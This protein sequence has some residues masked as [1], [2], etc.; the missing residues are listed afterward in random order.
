[1]KIGK[2]GLPILLALCFVFGASYYL[3][4]IYQ[5]DLAS[6]VKGAVSAKDDQLYLDSIP[7]PSGSEELGRNVRNDFA[8][9]T[10]SV[11]KPSQEV[12]KFFRSVLIS[13]GWKMQTEGDNLLSVIYTRDREKLEV[14]VLS[15]D[16]TQGT[17]FSLSHSY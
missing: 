3:F 9:L 11:S 13:K 10:A 12:Q 15:F 6:Q 2:K 8:Q 5:P 1:M 7:L 16:D 14:S 4:S 17:V